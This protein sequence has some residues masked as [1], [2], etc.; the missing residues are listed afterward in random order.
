MTLN[1]DMVK[2]FPFVIGHYNFYMYYI[3]QQQ[4]LHALAIS[5]NKLR[6]A[7]NYCVNSLLGVIKPGTHPTNCSTNKLICCRMP[8]SLD[9]S[10]MYNV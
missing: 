4:D 1:M 5:I 3:V 6:A 7:K 10:L 2:K 8:E 9:M